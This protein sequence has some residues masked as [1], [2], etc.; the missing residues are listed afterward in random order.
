MRSGLVRW[1]LWVRGYLGDLGV[2]VSFESGVHGSTRSE[3]NGGEGLV[4]CGR[5]LHS[6]RWYYFIFTIIIPILACEGVC[7]G[8]DLWGGG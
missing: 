4:S 3:D 7:E 6:S 5:T 1:C 8:W 2:N